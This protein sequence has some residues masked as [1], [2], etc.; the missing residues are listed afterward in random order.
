MKCKLS[1]KS[2]CILTS[3]VLLLTIISGC[4][5]NNNLPNATKTVIEGNASFASYSIEELAQQAHTI[6]R[7]IVI[8][9][10]NPFEIR[11]GSDTVPATPFTIKVTVWIKGDKNTDVVVYNQLGGETEKHIMKP[12]F[13][14]L[15][16]S[17]DVIICLLA[18]G[19][20]FGPDAI[21][22]ISDSLTT[23]QDY[24]IPD[25]EGLSS[26]KKS[27]SILADDLI[28]EFIKWMK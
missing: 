27:T 14:Q 5:S 6:V 9:K 13:D 15:S 22:K 10:G 1:V 16:I 28:G 19:L 21:F 26:D 18:D 7:G 23:I 11:F 3:L 8:S 2:G 4:S 12:L 25:Y 17:D 20:D 24:Q